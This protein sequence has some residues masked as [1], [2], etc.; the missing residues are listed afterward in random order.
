[1]QKVGLLEEYV[2]AIGCRSN[3]SRGESKQAIGDQC[4]RMKGGKTGKPK[5]K[6]KWTQYSSNKLKCLK[7]FHMLRFSKKKNQKYI[8]EST[9]MKACDNRCDRGGQEA[10]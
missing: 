8:Y 3:L 2:F 9:H 7:Y 4:Q 5:N 6:W 1:M 10:L